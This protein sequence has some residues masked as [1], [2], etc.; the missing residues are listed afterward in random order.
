[1]IYEVGQMGAEDLRGFALSLFDFHSAAGTRTFAK[2]SPDP[3]R[4]VTLFD[5]EISLQHV[6]GVTR[7][8][9]PHL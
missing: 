7:H 8:K 5:I 1:M 2:S 9:V 6:S 3:T 4:C